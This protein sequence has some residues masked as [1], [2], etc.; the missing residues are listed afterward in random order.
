MTHPT[1]RAMRAAIR[2]FVVD[3]RTK[4]RSVGL[5]TGR[6]SRILFGDSRVLDQL[7]QGHTSITV[8]RVMRA[9]ERLTSFKG[10][11]IDL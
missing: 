4:A 3:A 5:S 1:T 11:K 2:R 10:D 7:W 6:M 8:A 9:A